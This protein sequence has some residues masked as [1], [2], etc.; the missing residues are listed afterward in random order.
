VCGSGCGNIFIW[1]K[2]SGAIVQVIECT[3]DYSIQSCLPHPH[4]PIIASTAL[5]DPCVKL[6]SPL[7]KDIQQ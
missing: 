7:N 5:L 6:W 1:E 3:Q 4:L 2:K